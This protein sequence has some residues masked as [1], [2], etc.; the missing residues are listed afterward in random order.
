MIRTLYQAAVRWQADRASFLG[1][2][3]AYYA[4]FSTVPLLIVS[5]AVAGQ[6][7]GKEAAE[8]KLVA[9]LSEHIGPESAQNLQDLVRSAAIGSGWAALFGSLLLLFTAMGLFLQ[10]RIALQIIWKLTPRKEDIV[11]GTVRGYLLAFTSMLIVVVFASLIV[12]GS[13]TLT[14]VLEVWG[15]RYFGSN[16]LFLRLAN[17]AASLL[18]LTLT[19]LFLFRLLSERRIPYRHLVTGAFVTAALFVLGKYLFGLY[20]ASTTLRSA[21]GAASSLVVFLVWVYYS[22][23]LIFFGAE[24]VQI[25]REAAQAT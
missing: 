11:T 15:Q 10:L 21:Y 9:T 2:A 16:P 4:L 5:I 14:L 3:I 19:V 20:L 24:V 1:A 18:V 17:L 25:R 7:Y 23:Q 8:G 12:G 13:T 22:A 6:F